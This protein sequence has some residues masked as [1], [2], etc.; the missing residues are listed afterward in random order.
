MDEIFLY[1]IALWWGHKD[2]Y[3]TP[4][5]SWEA[6]Q[7]IVDGSRGHVSDGGDTEVGVIMFCGGAEFDE[8]SYGKEWKWV[9]TEVKDE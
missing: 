2:I 4:M 1:V 3:R 7:T 9:P 8:R 5:P 6:C